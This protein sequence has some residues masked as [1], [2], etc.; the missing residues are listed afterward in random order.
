MDCP[1]CEKEMSLEFYVIGDQEC[2]Q[3][4]YCEPCDVEISKAESDAQHE[5]DLLESE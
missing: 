4:Y 3:F 1:K 2:G 5:Q